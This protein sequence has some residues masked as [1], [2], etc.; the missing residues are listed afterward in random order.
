MR[1]FS[2][3]QLLVALVILA[4]ASF[5]IANAVRGGVLGQALVVGVLCTGLLVT[6]SWMFAAVVW[7]YSV[8]VRQISASFD[9]RS[10]HPAE[11]ATEKTGTDPVD[12][13]PTEK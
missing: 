11:M 4:L 3:K 9:F 7:F 8:L 1:Q 5:S 13:E 2:L 12:G 10:N 6:T